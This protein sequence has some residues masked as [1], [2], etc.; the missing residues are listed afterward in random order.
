MTMP[1]YC[2]TTRWNGAHLDSRI[3]TAP[4]CLRSTHRN[5]RINRQFRK[6]REKETKKKGSEGSATIVPSESKLV[7]TI[8]NRKTVVLLAFLILATIKLVK[9]V[10][11]LNNHEIIK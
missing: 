11:S 5:T 3:S 4:N 9:I 6:K 10:D 8:R 7:S 1:R 2:C